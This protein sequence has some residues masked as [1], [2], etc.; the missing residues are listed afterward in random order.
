MC[1][2][3]SIDTTN[4]VFK[5]ATDAPKRFKRI[6]SADILISLLFLLACLI[7]S[8]AGNGMYSYTIAM[9]ISIFYIVSFALIQLKKTQTDFLTTKH[10]DGKVSND[11]NDDESGKN[12]NPFDL[13]DLG[14]TFLS[15]LKFVFFRKDNIA[16]L[17]A[18]MTVIATIFGILVATGGIEGSTFGTAMYSSV[19]PLLVSINS[20]M[21]FKHNQDLANPK[22]ANA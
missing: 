4:L 15:V 12:I 17:A 21:L 5:L 13:D 19:G 8:G 10:R 7:V 16:F 3:D 14:E 20:I 22:K 9:F 1:I 2:R 11:Y 18:I 6:R